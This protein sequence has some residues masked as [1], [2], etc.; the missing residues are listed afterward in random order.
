MT[1]AQTLG[2]L[3]KKTSIYPHTFLA[4]CGLSQDKMLAK[5][6]SEGKFDVEFSDS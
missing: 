2:T 4:C 5:S 6:K 3:E 1:I